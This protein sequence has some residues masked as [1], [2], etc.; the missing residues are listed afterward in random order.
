V[1]DELSLVIR[2]A[3]TMDD[4]ADHDSAEGWMHP[5]IDGVNRLH[6]VMTV[7]ERGGCS[8]C[9]KPLAIDDRM[10]VCLKDSSLSDPDVIECSDELL[11]TA[12]HVVFVFW[13][14]TYARYAD[15]VSELG[16]ESLFFPFNVLNQPVHAAFLAPVS[17]STIASGRQELKEQQI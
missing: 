5:L 1:H 17:F 7:D 8:G 16:Y 12:T 10:A 14:S 15:E 11:G 4:V 13:K 3:A 9:A 6:I 2:R